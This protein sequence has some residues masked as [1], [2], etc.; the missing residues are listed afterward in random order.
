MPKEANYQ[1]E[2]E[3]RTYVV[4]YYAASD[5]IRKRE[6]IAKGSYYTAMSA[7]ILSAFTFE[8]YLNHLGAAKLEF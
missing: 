8:A 3:L 6:Q 4:L 1:A 2:R 7:L 5:L